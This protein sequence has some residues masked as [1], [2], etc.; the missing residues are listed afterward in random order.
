MT[1]REKVLKQVED[2]I[3]IN[4]SLV[5]NADVLL[6]IA[7]EMAKAL[8]NGNKVVLFGNGGSAADAEHIA[9]ELAGKFLKDR[10]PL[11]AL[12]L[13]ASTTTLTAIANDYGYEHVFSRQVR[14]LVRS[15]DV[16][17]GISTS[18]ES[19]NVILGIEEANR[20]GAVTVAFSGA[21]G[22]LNKIARHTLAVPSKETPRVQETH[23]TAGHIICGLVEEALFG[24]GEDSQ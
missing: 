21:S 22:R 1:G 13:S 3:R 18:G 12:A 15:G 16:V 14:G 7:G 20:L 5:E 19:N 6:A 8:K 10:A 11:A 24:V 2:S 17:I 23:I 9:T 4:K